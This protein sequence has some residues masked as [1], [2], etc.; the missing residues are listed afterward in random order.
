MYDFVKNHPIPGLFFR[1]DIGF[2]ELSYHTSL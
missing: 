2:S 1:E